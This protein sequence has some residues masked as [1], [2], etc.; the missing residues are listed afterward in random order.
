MFITIELPTEEWRF[1]MKK[2]VAKKIDSTAWYIGDI[3]WDRA[4][5]PF[6]N[7]SRADFDDKVLLIM[8]YGVGTTEHEINYIKKGQ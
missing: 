2:T 3:L 1:D 4:H 5:N 8:Y 7:Y 6:E